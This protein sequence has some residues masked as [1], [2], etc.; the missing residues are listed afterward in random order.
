VWR[1]DGKWK[2]ESKWRMGLGM[3][4]GVEVGEERVCCVVWCVVYA[5]SMHV[6]SR[7]FRDLP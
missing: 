4:R 3:V 2:V 5:G 1:E 7:G 6:L